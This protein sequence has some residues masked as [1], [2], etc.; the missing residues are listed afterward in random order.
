MKRGFLHGRADF[1]I[2]VFT[3]VSINLNMVGVVRITKGICE[4]EKKTR[5]PFSLYILSSKSKMR[6]SRDMKQKVY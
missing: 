1:F 5:K 4:K 2:F 6:K 3:N